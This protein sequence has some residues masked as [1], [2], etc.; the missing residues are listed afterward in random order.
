M[1]FVILFTGY[2]LLD[3]RMRT[4]DIAAA[5]T[6]ARRQVSVYLNLARGMHCLRLNKMTQPKIGI[7]ICSVK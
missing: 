4:V 6:L 7:M 1:L 5:R 2:K 3:I